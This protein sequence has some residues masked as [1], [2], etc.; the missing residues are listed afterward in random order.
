MT[1]DPIY[2]YEV[3]DSFTWGDLPTD[4]ARPWM[5]EMNN[6]ILEYTDMKFVVEMGEADYPIKLVR[7]A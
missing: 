2:T 5:G 6:T 7:E 3:I 1:K 4:D